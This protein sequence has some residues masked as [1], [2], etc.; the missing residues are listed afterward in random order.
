MPPFFLETKFG[1]DQQQSWQNWL[2]K[3]YTTAAWEE[4]NYLLQKFNVKLSSST[5]QTRLQ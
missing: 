4:Q 2:K 1:L 3:M 5:K